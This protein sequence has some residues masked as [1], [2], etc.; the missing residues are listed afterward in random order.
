MRSASRNRSAGA[1]Q[2][3]IELDGSSSFD[4]LSQYPAG[5]PVPATVRQQTLPPT[6]T[7][8]GNARLFASLHRERFRHV[9]GL[10]W[11][12]WDAYR[13]KRVG[14]EKTALWAAG[15]MSEQMSPT[16]PRGIFSEEDIAKHRQRSMSTV[17]LRALLQQAQASPE[18]S[19]DPGLLDGDP[20][21]LCTPKGAVD[22]RTGVLRAPDPATALNSRATT[23]APSSGPIP[24]WH[25]FLADTFGNDARG[26]EMIDFLH[27]LLGYS[28]TGDVGAQILPFLW[29]KGANGKSVLLDVV[30]QVLGDY[31]EAAP[32]GF[33]MEKGPYTEHATELTELHGRRLVVC[34]E[35]RPSA[36]FDEV[37]VKHLTGGEQ[38]TARRMRQD[39][40]SFTPTHKLWLLGNHYPEVGTGG[41]AFWRRI[42]LI[43]FERVIPAENKVDNL[44]AELVLEEGPGILQWLID[45]AILYLAHRGHL[46]GP[47]AVRLA[48]AAYES[49]EDHIGRFLDEQCT[50]DSGRAAELRV[51]QRL[52][53]VA[54]TRWCVAE[55]INA[56]TPRAFAS[57]VRNEVGLVSPAAMLKSKGRKY[58]P[59]IAL[60]DQSM[61]NGC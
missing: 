44:A 56:A 38:I 58:Y 57:R 43:P 46:M 40:F 61:T 47:D 45:G 23:V 10:G 54:Y 26:Q 22:L 15:E 2:Q 34:S 17:G 35:L 29:G 6:L 13:W 16:D 55:G 42:R 59:A 7:D 9:D 1:G 31:A 28:I 52:L 11:L 12:V 60:I 8:H 24:R 41:H 33:L 51:E 5:S 20:Y 48:T 39:Y 14:G 19:L 37:K 3:T 27:L 25:A 21:L 18:L 36:R 4:A 30:M 53:Y 49:T 50:R 32:P